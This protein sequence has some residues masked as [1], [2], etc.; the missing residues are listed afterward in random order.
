M[1]KTKFKKI[2]LEHIKYNNINT[3]VIKEQFDPDD[4]EDIIDEY[5][6]YDE[7]DQYEFGSYPGSFSLWVV[8]VNTNQCSVSLP[9]SDFYICKDQDQ[10][11][12]E[13][14]NT[15]LSG[16]DIGGYNMSS[17]DARCAHP[18]ELDNPF[19]NTLLNFLQWIMGNTPSNE[20]LPPSISPQLANIFFTVPASGDYLTSICPACNPVG[21]QG[22]NPD[23]NELL[24][25]G[26]P[27]V[28]GDNYVYDADNQTY[29]MSPPQPNDAPN[30]L[31]WV[32][33]SSCVVEGCAF[34]AWDNYILTVIGNNGITGYNTGNNL[35]LVDNGT[36]QATGCLDIITDDNYICTSNPSL[37]PGTNLLG[38]GNGLQYF[39]SQND[40]GQPNPTPNQGIP[41]GYG[42]DSFWDTNN[43]SYN[44]DAWAMG[45][46]NPTANNIPP[47]GA[48][49][50][51]NDPSACTQAVV[52]GCT[53]SNMTNYNPA[54]NVE[55]G[56]CEFVG[57]ANP[58]LT[59]LPEH[60]CN[61]N[62]SLCFGDNT[63]SFNFT[64]NADELGQPMNSYEGGY[65]TGLY[66]IAEGALVIDDGTT[67]PL[68]QGCTFPLATNYNSNANY[69]DGSCYLDACI[70]PDS[71]N[72]ICD[73][74]P[75]VCTSGV[76]ST[77]YTTYQ[78]TTF[79][80]INWIGYN[81]KDESELCGEFGCT[82]PAPGQAANIYIQWFNEYFGDSTLPNLSGGLTYSEQVGTFSPNEI[83]DAMIAG[84][85]PQNYIEGDNIEE[86]G[87]CIFDANGSGIIDA[88]D[89]FGCTS[90]PS[91]GVSTTTN[92]NPEATVDDDSCIPIVY[93]CTDKGEFDDDWWNGQGT[94]IDGT[95]SSNT[96]Y[97]P[98]TN[99][100]LPLQ[101]LAP[102]V[103]YS[104]M[105]N[106]PPTYQ[107]Q[108][109]LNWNPQANIDDGSCV[110]DFD[111][112]GCLHLG[113][114]G[115]QSWATNDISILNGNIEY[116]ID[117]NPCGYTL[118]CIDESANNTTTVP[119]TEFVIDNG[120]CTYDV[121]GCTESS[122]E[123]YNE[124][125]N[126]EDGSC[127]FE[128]CIQPMAANQTQLQLD[129]PNS[130][131]Y[132]S[133]Y[134]FG[135]L[136]NQF[137]EPG[138]SGQLP[139][140]NFGI[141]NGTCQFAG[142]CT[143]PT[144]TNYMCA[145]PLF[146]DLCALDGNNDFVPNGA[147]FI[148]GGLGDF[149][150][151]N[152]TYCDGGGTT[153]ENIGCMDPFAQNF[154]ATATADNAFPS[155]TMCFYNYCG[156]NPELQ[157][158]GV[159]DPVNVGATFSDGSYGNYI[160]PG[161]EFTKPIYFQS[162]GIQ[163]GGG[164]WTDGDI[165]DNEIC[166]YEGCGGD[167]TLTQLQNLG[168]PSNV[169]IYSLS[170][171][172][173]TPGQVI[174]FTGFAGQTLFSQ[175]PF[176]GGCDPDGDGILDAQ[177]ISCCYIPGCTED[178]SNNFN[179]NA[180]FDDGSCEFNEGCTNP[181]A[182]NYSSTAVND[183]GS[184]ELIACPDESATNY[185]EGT[186]IITNGNDMDLCQYAGCTDPNY[187]EYYYGGGENQ[188][189]ATTFFSTYYIDT[190]GNNLNDSYYL[191]NPS[192]VATIDDGSCSTLIVEGCPDN[193]AANYNDAVNVNDGSCEPIVQGCMDGG[194]GS[195]VASIF[196]GVEWPYNQALDPDGSEIYYVNNGGVPTPNQVNDN[197]PDQGDFN[198]INPLPGYPFGNGPIT[199]WNGSGACNYNPNANYDD[200]SCYYPFQYDDDDGNTISVDCQGNEFSDEEIEEV[201]YGCTD[202]S[203]CN[204]NEDA[205][206][207]DGSC[208]E[209]TLNDFPLGSNNF[210][211]S[212]AYIDN[213]I[214]QPG[215]YNTFIEAGGTY[216][217]FFLP[218]VACSDINPGDPGW[219]NCLVY[220][221]NE[222]ECDNINDLMNP[223]AEGCWN[224]TLEQCDP[225]LPE[226]V[227]GVSRQIA[228]Q[229]VRV[230]GQEPIEGDMVR[231]SGMIVS[232]GCTDEEALNYEECAGMDDGSCEYPEPEYWGCELCDFGDSGN[233]RYYASVWDWQL[234][235]YPN[236]VT[237]D[238]FSFVTG[239]CDID[240][241]TGEWGGSQAAPVL[242]ANIAEPYMEWHSY[243]MAA[244]SADE[245]PG[246]SF[247]IPSQGN[248]NMT[249]EENLES[250]GVS[251]LFT[252]LN[253]DGILTWNNCDMV[254]NMYNS[255]FLDY[256]KG[257]WMSYC[258]DS[259][260]H[261][262]E[263]NMGLQG[264]E[265]NYVYVPIEHNLN[266]QDIYAT[267]DSS[268]AGSPFS[269]GCLDPNASN[270][271]STAIVDD[272][273][274]EFSCC[275]NVGTFCQ[276]NQCYNLNYQPTNEWNCPT[277]GL[278]LGYE[279]CGYDEDV[280]SV[281]GG[282]PQ[283][284]D[285]PSGDDDNNIQSG[286]VLGIAD[287][288]EY[289]NSAEACDSGYCVN[290]Q[291]AYYMYAYTVQGGTGEVLFKDPSQATNMQTGGAVLPTAYQQCYSDC[292]AT[293]NDGGTFTSN[294]NCPPGENYPYPGSYP[295]TG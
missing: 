70:N 162:D 280:Y 65:N 52:E 20:G 3:K 60:V 99:T 14:D 244:G 139:I 147:P 158:A 171:M 277:S 253:P 83:V 21:G 260:I 25:I 102:G 118:A 275:S 93:G 283:S 287:G 136:T 226:D 251:E 199:H 154:D 134:N 292:M 120:S 185:N 2:L 123:N 48:Y 217:N 295:A 267:M 239:H 230:E 204:F 98:D 223:D 173:T 71:P 176:N 115:Y 72:Y 259:N 114:P 186:E 47:N 59:H 41:G 273:S 49:E 13:F 248:S 279:D 208:Y 108:Q 35:T 133:N 87:S 177:D 69:D 294:D 119:I 34:S 172:G 181:I 46:G 148:E 257:L 165:M 27:I 112:D 135:M 89:V 140:P 58:L 228:V 32:D 242:L 222:E 189:P 42:D 45:I 95:Q 88:L 207:D 150:V 161:S 29:Q 40:G 127:Q 164:P 241:Y 68:I 129:N 187:L 225:C 198:F 179:P 282:D 109:A 203:A 200:A 126:L 24:E 110:Y 224:V 265:G 191:M 156:I 6:T 23:F 271:D 213:M 227:T 268:T 37:C 62:P 155:P 15:F 210:V 138:T 168:M 293:L 28:D 5:G 76:P 266:P 215:D 237:G 18:A 182:S 92:F 17:D 80:E 38:L 166:K 264:E 39:N 245:S 157:A 269:E 243:V 12:I 8:N 94:N 240:G 141:D 216:C 285:M 53:N 188:I 124:E 91:N 79:Q 142:Y 196:N 272:G 78:G 107:S 163:Y 209:A 261:G 122:A 263:Y 33:N 30:E 184:C 104:A 57:C 276:D 63:L 270:A 96:I 169:D 146:S 202:T 116:D 220:A 235:N 286:E 132:G 218:T 288:S 43:D 128:G 250:L 201:V 121:F 144:A 86:D 26:Y 9:I 145:N 130:I 55:D 1:K 16:L 252:G 229:C 82:F 206:S 113:A 137:S 31:Q 249:W 61:T 54:A 258:G 125:A 195:P 180:T 183:D 85:G 56:T 214:L 178:G 50:F 19:E 67:C 197:I 105:P 238:V 192:T 143:D 153:V 36:C 247:W 152:E 274:C 66:Y 77:S 246:T 22:S 281:I 167:Y 101:T 212:S 174:P 159:A 194:Y 131:Y 111:I 10:T 193:T 211:D 100:L 170:G 284:A 44:P 231:H 289:C 117:T 81:T 205:N 151:D 232:Y 106:M 74:L 4:Y 51:I 84:E 221:C 90:G 190:T 278:N 255:E 7:Y 149:I 290:G 64:D 236:C 233:V 160:A 11:N 254:L 103:V 75:E 291:S 219:E 234:D 262:F 97:I 256:L 73:T 175:H